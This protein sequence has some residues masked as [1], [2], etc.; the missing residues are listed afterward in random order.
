MSATL[1]HAKSLAA[2]EGDARWF[3]HN[4][5]TVKLT[6][7]ETGGAF[8]LVEMVAAQGDMPPL[9]VHHT[10]DET[11]LLLDGTVTMFVGDSVETV[12]AGSVV[13][14]PR[15]VPHVYRVDSPAARWLVISSPPAFPEFVL[16]ASVPAEADTLPDGP[17]SFTPEQL[18]EIASRYGI[19]ILGPPGTL[20]G[21][22]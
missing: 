4:L 3:I 2:G 18:G 17:P 6:G 20:P 19:E 12:E 7:A 21:E 14:A 15:G 9:H 13:L 16:E 5:A 8:S 1:T 22:R 11:F 10:D